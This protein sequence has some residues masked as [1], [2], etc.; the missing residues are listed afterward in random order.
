LRFGV[1]VDE[2]A[3]G[4][5]IR[6]SVAVLLNAYTQG[7]VTESGLPGVGVVASKRADVAWQT[8]L[9]YEAV[10]SSRVVGKKI[11]LLAS[12]YWVRDAS[13]GSRS[14]KT[15]FNGSQAPGYSAQ[16]S[17]LGADGIDLG[18]GAGVN[19]TSRTSARLNGVW[20]VRES[21]SQPGANLGIT[22]EF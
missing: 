2:L 16:G 10:Q 6:P 8:R 17:A 3:K 5:K 12:A 21:S 13:R 19:L 20:Q 7:G 14:V 15:R 9:G 22:V 18:V 11:D 1:N 4:L